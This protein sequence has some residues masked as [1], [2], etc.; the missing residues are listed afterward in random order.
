[1]MKEKIVIMMLAIIM[2]LTACSQSDIPN[3]EN[4]KK[5]QW[6]NQSEKNLDKTIDLVF[7]P[8]SAE[9]I[10]EGY[11]KKDW[12]E[13][14]RIHFEKLSGQ[15]EATI[16]LYVDTNTDMGEQNGRTIYAFLEHEGSLYEI[17]NVSNYGIEDVHVELVDRTFDGIKE[18]EIVGGM[19]STYLEMKIIGY[20]E[21]S[22]QWASLLVMGSPQIVDLDED[23]QE[24]IVGI[25]TGSLP[26][27]VE[28]Y[29]WDQDHF[30]KADI[31]DTTDNTYANL[32]QQEGKWIIESG[33]WENGKIEDRKFYRYTSGRLIEQVMKR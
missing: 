11:P 7:T 12:T 2:V 27:F 1:M 23:G 5:G 26:G 15:I 8:V 17:G 6:E 32:Y 13:E 29:R 28:V 18:I 24:E 9:K 14:K 3:N 33:K 25:S 20:N 30:E 22:K 16:H 21:N 10:K 19:G 4:N 31:A